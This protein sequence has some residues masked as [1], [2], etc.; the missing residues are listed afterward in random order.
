ML[1]YQGNIKLEMYLMSIYICSSCKNIHSPY[2]Y[3]HLL[4]DNKANLDTLMENILFSLRI[5]HS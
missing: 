1:L 3:Q 4:I 2:S 5:F